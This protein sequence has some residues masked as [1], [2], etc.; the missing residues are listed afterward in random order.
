MPNQKKIFTVQNL[1]EK[2]KQA[3]AFV[4]ADYQGLN[5]AQ[6]NELRTEV[7]KTGGEFEVIKNTLFCLAAKNSQ[8]PISN[9]QLEGPTAA[10]W[11]YKEDLSPLKSLHN[12]I[13]KNA[14][15]RIKLGFWEGKPI[16]IE[17]IKKLANL[18]TRSEL[19]AK[20]VGLVQSPT[21]GLTTAL[22]WNL[23]KLLFT[24]KAVADST[25]PAAKGGGETKN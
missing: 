17:R 25:S 12:F 4:L 6:I 11:V 21:F 20:L 14:L 22:N 13:N 5:A 1:A 16:S 15:P 7:K 24:I 3:K 23:K 19:E 9:F 2:F 8:F 10:L 18:P